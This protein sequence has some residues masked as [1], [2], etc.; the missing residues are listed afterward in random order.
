M[1][2]T[3]LRDVS[4]AF[5]SMA[6]I[7]AAPAPPA[8]SAFGDRS[9]ARVTALP[10]AGAPMAA[11]RGALPKTDRTRCIGVDRVAGAV[12]FGDHAVE[13][14]MKDGSRWR[15]SFAE[16]CPALSFY[17][18][19][20][21]RRAVAGRLCAGRDAVISR[22]GGECPIAAITLVRKAKGVKRRR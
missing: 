3:L 21:Y 17:Q 4:L 9:V 2:R 13:L 12:V 19:F 6:V 5:A 10:A 1:R 8:N 18:G 7:G 22:A 14:T 20:Y 11:S 16:E 15:M